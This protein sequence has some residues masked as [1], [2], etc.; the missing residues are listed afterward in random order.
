MSTVFILIA[1]SLAAGVALLLLR[2]L[3]R[4]RDDGRPVA[5]PAALVLAFVLFAGGGALYA[6]FSNYSWDTAAATAESPAARA[7]ARPVNSK[8]APRLTPEL[9]LDS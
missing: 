1:G 2:P 8:A 6:A 7:Y 9:A 3:V 4:R 5:L